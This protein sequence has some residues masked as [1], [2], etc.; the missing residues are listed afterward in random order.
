MLWLIDF[1]LYCL[2]DPGLDAGNFIGHVTEQ[3]L[4]QYGD[5]H[6]LARFEQGMGAFESRDYETARKHF[7]RAAGQ[8]AEIAQ[9]FSAVEGVL[10][11]EPERLDL[12]D[13]PIDEP[14]A[15]HFEGCHLA[16]THEP[17]GFRS[18]CSSPGS[19]C[20]GKRV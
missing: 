17:V 8:A 11:R 19:G 15:A 20:L 10:G 16:S 2:G 14:I 1:D 18:D 9:A 7:E 6:R 13:M 12:L 5:A 3:A 4:R